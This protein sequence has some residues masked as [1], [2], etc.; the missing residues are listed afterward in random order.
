M[1]LSTVLFT[2][3]VDK[4]GAPLNLTIGLT[5]GLIGII[6]SFVLFLLLVYKGWSSYWVAP[7]AAILVALTNAIDPLKAFEATYIKG[8][9]DLI[10]ELFSII[11]LGAIFGKIFT[12]TGAASSLAKTLTD[13]FI[14]KF[15]GP[16]QVRV[17]LLCLMVIAGACT[18]GG[19]DG[20]VL[21]FSLFPVCMIIAEMVNIPRRF[22]PGML[23][24]NVAFMTMPGAPQI[25][26]VIGIG[27][28][29]QAAGLKGLSVIQGDILKNLTSTAGLIPGVIACIVIA[30]VAYLV[31]SQ[32]I[33]KA[34]SKGEVFEYGSVRRFEV[35][36]RKLPNVFVAILPLL[37]V[38][39]MYTILNLNIAIALA[40]GIL[41]NII[42]MYV[43]IEKKDQFNLPIT[44]KRALMNSLNAGANS[45]PNALMTIITPAGLAAVVG[46]TAA[47]MLITNALGMLAIDPLW[48][49]LILVCVVVGLTSSPPAALMLAL[50]VIMAVIA[51]TGSPVNPAH[52]TRVAIIAASTF[53]TLPVNG[54]VIV[55]LGLAHVN[56]KQGYKPMFYMTVLITLLGSIV[57]AALFYL[58]P[59]LS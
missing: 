54:L 58:F 53:E 4:A 30:I 37:T 11:F 31:L 6:V 57:A 17:A 25:Y 16:A 50:P 15:K 56:H 19:I 29:K 39:I 18:M 5:I 59:G 47:Y 41:V 38:F 7:L 49:T 23:C 36:E 55:A 40:S 43:Y 51:R 45:Y 33:I 32:M 13:R 46:S 2:L 3:G 1:D 26:N 48:L 42:V 52:I 20:F 14:V 10:F 9:A 34:M 27:A 44:R 8:M 22:V 21:I 12:D 28:A 35:V 24:L